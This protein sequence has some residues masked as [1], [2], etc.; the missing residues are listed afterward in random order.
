[1]STTGGVEGKKYANKCMTD[2]QRNA[3]RSNLVVFSTTL[4][5][6]AV[7]IFME[8]EGHLLCSHVET[9]MVLEF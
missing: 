7:I 2:I 1:M 6:D 3:I 9:I 8:S 4:N 5:I